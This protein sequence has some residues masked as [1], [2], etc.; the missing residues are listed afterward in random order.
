MK[1]YYNYKLLKLLDMNNIQYNRSE[2]FDKL[3]VA[4]SE[5]GNKNHLF[6]TDERINLVKSSLI[7]DKL[8]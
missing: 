8:S 3:I 2:I 6:T 5:G 4:V 7:K 1:Y